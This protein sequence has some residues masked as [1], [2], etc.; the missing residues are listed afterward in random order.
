MFRCICIPIL[1]LIFGCVDQ[2]R[3][4]LEEGSPTSQAQTD[5]STSSNS[6]STGD[7]SADE[8]EQS[9]SPKLK[10]LLN[11]GENIILPAYQALKDEAVSFSAEGGTLGMYCSGIGTEAEPE[12]FTKVLSDLRS[13]SERI[14]VVE[15]LQVGPL[16]S[17]SNGLHNRI[18]PYKDFSLATC[19]LDQ[20]VVSHADGD[21]DIEIR[22]SNQ[23]GFPAVEYLLA[24]SN[25]AHSCPAQV[26][27]TQEWNSLTE[28]D[29][30]KQ[31]CGLAVTIAND[32]AEAST[33]AFGAWSSDDG[34]YFDSFTSEENVG[35]NFQALS[36]ALFYIEKNTKS[37]KLT[38]PLGLDSDCSDTTCA[39]LVEAPYLGNSL[40]N[41]A[42]NLETFLLVLEGGD[43]FGFDDIIDEAGFPDVTQRFRDQVQEATENAEANALS[44][45]KQV[46]LLEAN[47]DGSACINA[48]ANPGSLDEDYPA[49]TLAGLVK[50]VTD[51]LKIDFV[52]IVE[53]SIPG[54]VQS[55]ND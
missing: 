52:T 30:K 40:N 35:E 15:V 13:L 4:V 29:R 18:H 41:I 1:F 47:G 11:V 20:A 53:V 17:E 55:D 46:D 22:A 31:R 43:G 14:Q 32:I 36:D 6:N 51:D 5:S 37:R 23:K 49:C 26:P 25:L 42:I 48:F 24:N 16:A 21:Y 8:S 19:S 38:V 12:R 39:S 27:V 7:T 3:D 10:V 2:S 34:G 50:R 54:N 28:A 44:L 45:A 33:A 9:S